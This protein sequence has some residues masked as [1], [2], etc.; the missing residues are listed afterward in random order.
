MLEVR[1]AELFGKI[2]LDEIRNNY[3]KEIAAIGE[4]MFQFFTYGLWEKENDIDLLTVSF[5][6]EQST[7][8]YHDMLRQ[9]AS[10]LDTI[11]IL[12]INVNSSAVKVSSFQARSPWTAYLAL[13]MLMTKP[14]VIHEYKEPNKSL[15]MLEIHITHLCYRVAEPTSDTDYYILNRY[16]EYALQSN[17]NDILICADDFYKN[18]PDISSAFMFGGTCAQTTV[19]FI[20][21]KQKYKTT[22]VDNSNDEDSNND[23]DNENTN[24]N[25][26]NNNQNNTVKEPNSGQHENTDDD[27]W[28]NLSEGLLFGIVAVAV[29]VVVAI[30]AIVLVK[31]K[32]PTEF[33][34]KSDAQ[35]PKQE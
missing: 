1:R 2:M 11:C 18:M 20:Q 6:T 5:F 26:N 34:R 32:S 25:D 4:S 33:A 13:P 31:R 10:F 29:V 21:N 30:L 28:F 23:V 27:T 35:E 7:Y 14:R 24:S 17:E 3:L 22:N 15:A 8:N 19:N 16:F 12:T 9:Y